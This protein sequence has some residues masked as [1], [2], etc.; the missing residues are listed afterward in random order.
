[1]SSHLLLDPPAPEKEIGPITDERNSFEL[2]ES[3]VTSHG[4]DF[5]NNRVSTELEVR[6]LQEKN[7]T[8]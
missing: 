8:S 2:H 6:T 4:V 5:I 7:D 1:M 3:E